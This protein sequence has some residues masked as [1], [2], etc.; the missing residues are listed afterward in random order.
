MKNMKFKV[1]SLVND[2][3]Q[4]LFRIVDE[5]GDVAL[6]SKTGVFLDGGGHTD[7][8]KAKRQVGYLNTWAKKEEKKGK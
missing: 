4:S 7:N 2:S 3:G 5:K 1:K 6:N 8:Q